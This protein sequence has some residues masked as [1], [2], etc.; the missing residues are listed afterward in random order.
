MPVQ[1][2]TK[3]VFPLVKHRG[4]PIFAPPELLHL[5]SFIG[6]NGGWNATEFGVTHQH[7]GEPQGCV[8]VSLEGV[9]WTRALE[10][11]RKFRWFSGARCQFP[12]GGWGLTY[13]HLRTYMCWSCL[14][15]W[16]SISGL[17]T[18]VWPQTSIWHTHA[19]AVSFPSPQLNH[20]TNKTRSFEV[21]RFGIPWPILFR[22]DS[23]HIPAQKFNFRSTNHQPKHTGTTSYPLKATP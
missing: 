7:T 8:D 22:D 4:F 23:L 9:V 16:P 12:N 15:N 2:P 1:I 5:E 20:T 10:V 6:A 17:S 3:H 19:F 13:W 18:S 21:W 11:G 14:Q